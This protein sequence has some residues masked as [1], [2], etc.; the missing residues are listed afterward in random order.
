L[1]SNLCLSR[2]IREEDGVTVSP[3][4]LRRFRHRYRFKCGKAKKCPALTVEYVC[5]RSQFTA[6]WEGHVFNSLRSLPLIFSDECRFC[7]GNDNRWVW[8]R[9]GLYTY[10]VLNTQSKLQIAPHHFRREHR[11]RRILQRPVWKNSRSNAFSAH[12]GHRIRPIATQSRCSG[13]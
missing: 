1:I 3:E 7:Y 4:T 12:G 10:S 9:P 8:R 5:A 6:D 13:A 11:C 2:I